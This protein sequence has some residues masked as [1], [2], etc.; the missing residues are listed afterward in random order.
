MVRGG[1]STEIQLKVALVA[2]AT[3]SDSQKLPTTYARVRLI[4]QSLGPDHLTE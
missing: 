3:S 4:P 1:L 2:S